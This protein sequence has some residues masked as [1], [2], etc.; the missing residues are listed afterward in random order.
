[1]WTFQVSLRWNNCRINLFCSFVIS[2]LLYFNQVVCPLLLWKAL[3]PWQNNF[4][5]CSVVKYSWYLTSLVAWTS[6]WFSCRE[7]CVS[8]P[9]HSVVVDD[10]SFVRHHYTCLLYMLGLPFWLSKKDLIT[11]LQLY[12]W[13]SK[14]ATVATNVRHWIILNYVFWCWWLTTYFYPIYRYASITMTKWGW[15][16]KEVCKWRENF[17]IP[18]TV[19]GVLYL[20]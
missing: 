17:R 16:V 18:H 20:R 6:F 13:E 4:F 3:W 10:H 11:L 8:S 5:C 1:M 19:C 2:E 12:Y 7:L 15:I 14:V 9:F